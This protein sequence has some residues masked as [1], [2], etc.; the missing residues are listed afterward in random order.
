MKN[1]TLSFILVFSMISIAA[2]AQKK[3]NNHKIIFQFTNATDT[4]QQKAIINQL[5]NLTTH[6]PKAKY[7][8]VIHSMG[9]PFV[10]SGKSKQIQAI[11][12]LRDKGVRFVVCENTLKSQKVTKDQL[13][14]EVEY[15]PVGIAEIVEK[16]EQGWSYIKGGF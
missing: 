2:L 1:L 5:N 15:V 12:T 4:L 6:W 11:K 16:Q 14:Q 3:P 13:I 7:E 9:L 8:V 10:M